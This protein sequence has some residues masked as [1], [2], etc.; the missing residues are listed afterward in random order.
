MLESREPHFSLLRKIFTKIINQHTQVKRSIQ[1][2]L[3]QSNLEC[4]L[5]L[6][7]KTLNTQKFQVLLWLYSGGKHFLFAMIVKRKRFTLCRMRINTPPLR[8]SA[9]FFDK[10]L[11]KNGIVRSSA[12]CILF[13]ALDEKNCI[14]T[15]ESKLNRIRYL[16]NLPR[17]GIDKELCLAF[18]M[19]GTCQIFISPATL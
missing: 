11:I 2:W 17:S 18:A 8:V 4:E 16:Q 10:Q 12:A 15:K 14:K 5:K 19:G 13:G 1:L 7:N 6:T 9:A 3:F